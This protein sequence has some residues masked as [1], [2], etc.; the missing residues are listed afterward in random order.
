[1][2]EMAYSLAGE[3]AHY[4]T[5]TNPAAP[6]RIPGGSSSGTAAAVAAGDADLGL[7]AYLCAY[8]AYVG[9]AGDAVG[10]PIPQVGGRKCR[11]RPWSL[12][13]QDR[14]SGSSSDSCSPLAATP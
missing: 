11:P 6:G 7:G 10:L 12:V 13:E 8:W 9:A 1:M 3:N 4:G 14:H 2:D 5:P